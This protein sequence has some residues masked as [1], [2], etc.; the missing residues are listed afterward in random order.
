M[1]R[2][3]IVLNFYTGFS[4]TGTLHVWTQAPTAPNGPLQPRAPEPPNPHAARIPRPTLGNALVR[5]LDGCLT[6]AAALPDPAVR[7]AAAGNV[8]AAFSRSALREAHLRGSCHSS[9]MLHTPADTTTIPRPGRSAD[10][11]DLR[12]EEI[13]MGC[14]QNGSSFRPGALDTTFLDAA[15]A[16]LAAV[17]PRHPSLASELR[18]MEVAWGAAAGLPEPVEAEV[19]ARAP[20]GEAPPPQRVYAPKGPAATAV[21]ATESTAP[22]AAADVVS[23][24][25]SGTASAVADAEGLVE[26]FLSSD[27][28]CRLAAG[29][30]LYGMPYDDPGRSS[31]AVTFGFGCG[32][33]SNGRDSSTRFHSGDDKGVEIPGS[34]PGPGVIATAGLA[35]MGEPQRQWP[36]HVYGQGQQHQHQHPQEAQAAVGPQR[37]SCDGAG[38]DATLLLLVEELCEVPALAELCASAA[39]ADMWPD[40]VVRVA[41]GGAEAA[42]RW[43]TR[44]GGQGHL[45]AEQLNRGSHEG[46]FPT[47]ALPS[48]Y[49][50]VRGWGGGVGIGGGG[51]G[52]DDV[53]FPG[54]G[55]VG[56]VVNRPG[57]EEAVEEVGA[58]VQR[59]MSQRCCR[60]I[61]A[62]LALQ[63]EGLLLGKGARAGDGVP[64][65]P[66]LLCVLALRSGE[67]RQAL[68]A[69]LAAAAAAGGGPVAPGAPRPLPHYDDDDDDQQQQQQ[70]QRRR[71]GPGGR[72]AVGLVGPQQRHV[73]GLSE[74]FRVVGWDLGEVMQRFLLSSQRAHTP[75]RESSLPARTAL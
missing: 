31:G 25:E 2:Y 38:E 70:Q 18:L 74:W 54:K 6:A 21:T 4:F 12:P 63:P 44:L 15:F 56:A 30:L 39:L 68:L 10:P 69:G 72:A 59:A 71:A 61:A 45:E 73:G 32:D 17:A 60:L 29:Q 36:Q 7:R 57:G 48:D 43:L 33:N 14:G 58:V 26:F 13:E 50:H 34:N 55:G 47:A 19:T 20:P 67:V 24:T 52:V 53:W 75:P 1:P 22:S 16:L 51:G 9:A 42:V 65:P 37:R 62:A 35:A 40:L 5:L 3:S 64:L 8:I 11:Y 23:G 66:Q 41:E 49:S 27:F 28:Q 46:V